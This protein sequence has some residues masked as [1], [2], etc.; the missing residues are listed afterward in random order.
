MGKNITEKDG[1]GSITIIPLV[2]FLF[3]CVF[4]ILF[5]ILF[6]VL[7]VLLFCCFV[8]FLFFFVEFFEKRFDIK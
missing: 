1:S 7:F 8:L 3:F 5:C 6:F 4:F 2:C